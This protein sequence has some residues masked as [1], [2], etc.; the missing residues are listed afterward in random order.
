MKKLLS[1]LLL[2]SF[3]IKAQDVTIGKQTW[4]TKNLDV[5]S[6]R[7]GDAIPQVQD[8]TAWEN[9]TTGAW[10]Y[11]QNKAA[12]G[13]KYGK[14]YN[15]YAV[16]DPRGL[17]PN[18]YHIPTDV[19]WTILT[20]NLGGESVASKKIKNSSGWQNNVNG[21]NSSGF[22]GLPGGYRNESGNFSGIG[23]EGAWW[24]SLEFIFRDVLEFAYNF[25]LSNKL[26]ISFSSFNKKQIGYSV[27]CLRD[28]SFKKAQ[29][30]TIGKQV[31]TSKNLDVETYRN[32]DI[33]PQ[34]Q[35]KEVWENLTT[36]AWCYYENKTANGTTYGKLYNWYAVNDPRG[37]APRGYHIPTDAEWTK[38]TDYLG[39]ESVAGKKMKSTSGWDNYGNGTNTTGFEGLP[40]G[41][42]FANS[43]FN[44]IGANGYWWSSSDNNPN[45]AWCRYLSNDDGSVVSYY[46]YKRSGFFVRC[47]KD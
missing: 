34:V 33:I 5:E 23:Y 26:G 14:L 16:N 13:T 37:L 39:G 30:V 44:Y 11:Y 36:G 8:N 9:L 31:W 10:C 2:L 41:C 25:E 18:G 12:N 15:W 19:E 27:R 28:L 42:R 7:N 22:A 45:N 6:Y 46:Y 4:A 35:D 32:G 1:F 38:L 17:A 3:T 40:G 47:I 20:D 21:T 29:E 24:S 43:N